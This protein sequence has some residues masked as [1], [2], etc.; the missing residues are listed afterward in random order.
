MESITTALNKLIHDAIVDYTNTLHE[1]DLLNCTIDDAISN[2]KVIKKSNKPKKS[3][4]D[5]IKSLP[6][7]TSHH[8]DTCIA[9]VGDCMAQCSLSKTQGQFCTACSKKCGEDGIPPNGTIFTR[10]SYHYTAPNGKSPKPFIESTIYKKKL[11]DGESPAEIRKYYEDLLFDISPLN[12]GDKPTDDSTLKPLKEKPSDKPLK[13]KPSDK[14]LKEKPSD[15][16]LKEKPS[17]TSKLALQA[18]QSD[19]LDDELTSDPIDI[20]NSY[21]WSFH[22]EDY[23]AVDSPGGDKQVFS[24]SGKLIGI[25]NHRSKRIIRY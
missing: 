11:K 14:P 21:P 17:K 3:K 1:N 24:T 12:W 4:P 8:F 23:L 9:L 15:K 7:W 18:E 6:M 20:P 16:P 22:D 5:V 2:F 19:D 10:N 25:F 13:E